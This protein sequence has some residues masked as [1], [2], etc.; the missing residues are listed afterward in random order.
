M[1]WKKFLKIII[2]AFVYVFIPFN[3]DLSAVKETKNIKFRPS[4]DN[5]LESAP[6]L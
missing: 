4:F 3:N 5:K 2:P 1:K 6:A